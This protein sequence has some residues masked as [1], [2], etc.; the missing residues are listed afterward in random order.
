MSTILSAPLEAYFAA[1]NRHDIDAMLEPF[2]ADAVVRD[3]GQELRGREAIRA[4]MEETTR[5]YRVSVEV[6]DATEADGRTL[7]TGLVAGTF[8][9]SPAKLRYAFTVAGGRI[10][11]L[12]I[13]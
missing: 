6:L 12:A 2:A 13:A 9:G 7:V 10:R 3:E 4:W 1:K 11:E 5:K 8:A